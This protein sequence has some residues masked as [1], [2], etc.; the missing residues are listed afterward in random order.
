MKRDYLVKRMSI[1]VIILGFIFVPGCMQ[2]A[3]KSEQIK[4]AL[5]VMKTDAA[6][7]GEPKLVDGSLFF[8]TTEM[9]GHFE[10]VDALK[11]RFD[12]TATFFMKSGDGFVRI[13]T[14]VM[15]DGT[16]AV[17]TLLDPEGPVIESIQKGEAFYGEVDILGSQYESGYEPIKN[18]A[19]EI[20]GIYYIG[21][22][23]Q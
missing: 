11:E 10:I 1:G 5:Q 20:I 23:K 12:C 13:S 17:G 6:A 22:Q 7:L 8:G 2:Q 9:N 18:V 21:Y 19:G 16:R 14:N 3:D 4:E 15:S